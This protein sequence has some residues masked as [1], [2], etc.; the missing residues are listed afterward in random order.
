[1]QRQERGKTPDSLPKPR[2]L[3]DMEKADM[4]RIRANCRVEIADSNH[5]RL[6]DEVE[7]Y[8][9]YLRIHRLISLPQDMQSQSNTMFRR[10][11]EKGLR[12]ALL[13][14]KGPEVPVGGNATLPPEAVIGVNS[15]KQTDAY[16]HEWFD[17]L[18]KARQN[19]TMDDLTTAVESARGRL[20]FQPFREITDRDEPVIAAGKGAG[21]LSLI[22]VSPRLRGCGLSQI[23]LPEV[24]KYYWQARDVPYVFVYGRTPAISREQEMKAEFEE[25]G[26][27]STQNLNRYIT[28]VLGGVKRDFGVGVNQKAGAEIICGLPDSV[29][30][31]ESLNCGYLAIYKNPRLQ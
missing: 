29:L 17:N 9:R 21:F 1:M 11:I 30:D 19:H 23:L 6:S 28:Q 16:P 4:E 10:I 31:R 5:P 2:G 14:Y 12:V 13:K 25:S 15:S 20:K 18:L 27:V 3:N 26:V 22:H 8:L 7:E 24:L